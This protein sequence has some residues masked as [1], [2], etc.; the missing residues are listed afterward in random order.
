M[1]LSD[2]RLGA[3]LDRLVTVRGDLVERLA[4]ALEVEPDRRIPDGGLHL[5]A[6]VQSAIAAIEAVRSGPLSPA[7]VP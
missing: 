6:D 1:N 7:G 4:R 5:L 3:L 2:D